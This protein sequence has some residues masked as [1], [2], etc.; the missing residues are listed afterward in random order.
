MSHGNVY[1]FAAHLLQEKHSMLRATVSGEA[2]RLASDILRKATRELI[3]SEQ[4][5]VVR[6]LE[7]ADPPDSLARTEALDLE[8]RISNQIRAE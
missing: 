5:G 6:E 3:L 2:F 4:V 7:L 1:V 8:R